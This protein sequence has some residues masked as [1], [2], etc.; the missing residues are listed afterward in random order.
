MDA[1]VFDKFKDGTGNFS[2]ALIEDPRGLLSLY[3][4]AH[5]AVPGDHV[6]DDA[7]AFTR[8]HLE[9]LKGN[10]GSPISNQIARALNIPLPRYLPQL[11]AMH[12][13]TEYEEE[14]AHN[15]TVMELARLEYSITRSVHLRELQAF[16]S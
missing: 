12:Y 15:V 2:T 13:I 8:S 5:M 14:E 4:A 7:I 1:D 16:C 3:N 9:A 10:L 11:E 6:L